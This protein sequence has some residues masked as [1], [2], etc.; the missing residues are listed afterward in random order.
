MQLLG[1]FRNERRVL[2]PGGLVRHKAGRCS[3]VPTA[4]PGFTAWERAERAQRGKPMGWQAT[5]A[6]HRH[7]RTQVSSVQSQQWLWGQ[8]L[9]F[10]L[11]ASRSKVGGWVVHEAKSRPVR[12]AVTSA[13]MLLGGGAPLLGVFLPLPAALTL[14]RYMAPSHRRP[15]ASL[16]AFPPTD[17][18][19]DTEMC[20]VGEEMDVKGPETLQKLSLRRK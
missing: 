2:S 19:K 12:P 4:A 18:G 5:Q 6:P 14:Q 3:E 20:S 7:L 1:L 9:T 10:S 17:T 8:D 13:P 11:E 16:Q 15:R